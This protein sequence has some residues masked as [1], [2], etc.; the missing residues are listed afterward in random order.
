MCGLFGGIAN[1]TGLT[2]TDGAQGMSDATAAFVA[3]LTSLAV[4]AEERGKDSTGAAFVPPTTTPASP[5]RSIASNPPRLSY[6]RACT[7][8]EGIVIRRG[9]G[10]FADV[11]TDADTDLFASAAVVLGHTRWATQ[12][13]KTDVTNMSPL[14]VGSLLGTHNGDITVST[15][16]SRA[17]GDPLP[18]I[19][20]GSTD[21]ERLY[22]ALH[23]ARRDRRKMVK[24]LTAIHGRAALAWIDRD[25][26]D[27]VYLA[28]AGLA[29]LSFTFDRHGNLYWAS[30]PRWFTT[31]TLDH[32][33]V[34]DAPD[35]VA[36]GSLLTL[37]VS[38]DRAPM[39]EDCRRFVPTV[40]A[41][42]ERLADLV[43]WRGFDPLVAAAD[44]AA[45]CHRVA[46]ATGSKSTTKRPKRT[47]ST[48]GAPRSKGASRHHVVSADDA[49]GA[50]SWESAE[51]QWGGRDQVSALEQRLAA[52]VED[53]N[54]DPADG[55]DDP[56]G[57]LDDEDAESWADSEW[58]PMEDDRTDADGRWVTASGND[59]PWGQDSPAAR[60]L[61]RSTRPASGVVFGGRALDEP[62]GAAEWGFDLYV[63][64]GPD[65]RWTA[66]IVEGDQGVAERAAEIAAM[67]SLLDLDDDAAYEAFAEMVLATA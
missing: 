33:V 55:W 23:L 46:P 7:T 28:R 30:N 34:F 12:G 60:G 16:P 48:T 31:V 57:P 24:V 62:V 47:T 35:L 25:R 50:W 59:D 49:M 15:V 56:L 1:L 45:L 67:R 6:D 58:D 66:L 18:P 26:G 39:V 9:P 65:T 43:V 14:S 44:R 10:T 19:V 13:S 11:F 61:S 54:L 40:R 53:V 32:G 17:A 3:T 2:T 42:D 21:S 36:E 4:S 64:S 63:G 22:G 37:R 38:P 29:P 8:D 41:K 5:G 27:R 20:R 51:R 52:E